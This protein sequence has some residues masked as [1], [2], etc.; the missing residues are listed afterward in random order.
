V[1]S[2]SFCAS[3]KTKKGTPPGAPRRAPPH[4]CSRAPPDEDDSSTESEIAA[5]IKRV[6]SPMHYER[7]RKREEMDNG[8]DDDEA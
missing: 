8:E 7:K 4:V 2:F 6:F 5:E 1:Y 3:K